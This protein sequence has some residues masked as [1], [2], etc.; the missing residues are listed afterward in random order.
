MGHSR[1]YSIC[2]DIVSGYN[3][4]RVGE[5]SVIS[6]I[7]N[8]GLIMKSETIKYLAE[9]KAKANNINSIYI[10]SDSAYN[11]GYT[12]GKQIATND[13]INAVMKMESEEK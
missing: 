3:A 8:G 4:I 6:I 5:R 12:K 2:I 7:V 13:V 1:I 11:K 10:T 9:L